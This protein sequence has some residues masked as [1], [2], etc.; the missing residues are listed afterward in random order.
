M[1]EAATS[2]GLGHGLDEP[3]QM[4]LMHDGINSIFVSA[5]KHML[6]K[7]SHMPFMH[8]EFGLFE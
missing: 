1:D 5:L 3:H 8:A 4:A 7:D 2:F 6:K